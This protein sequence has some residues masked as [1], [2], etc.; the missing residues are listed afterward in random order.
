VSPT[1]IE[2]VKRA[3]TAA[4]A[5][6]TSSGVPAELVTAQCCLESAYLTKCAAPN[7]Y[8][9]IKKV[10]RHKGSAIAETREYIDGEEVSRMERFASF[11][12]VEDC[13]ADYALIVTTMPAYRGAWQRYQR[14]RDMNTLIGGVARRWATDPRYAEKVRTLAY[15]GEIRKACTSAR[16]ALAANGG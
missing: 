13:F 11:D 9:G 2:A 1:Q 16:K 8:F 14:D 10:S 5:I 7:N 12:S 6:E 15:S 3:A 4:V